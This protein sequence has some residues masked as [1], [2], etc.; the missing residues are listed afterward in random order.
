[1]FNTAKW[2][3]DNM[4]VEYNFTNRPA[5]YT[6]QGLGTIGSL[7]GLFKTFQHNYFG[8][9]AQYARTWAKNPKSFEAASPLL[10][11][12]VS[13]VMTAGLFGVMAVNQIDFL[14]RQMNSAVQT[15]LKAAGV[16][17]PGQYRIPEYTET[18]LKL[19]IPLEQKFGVPSALVNSD[20]SSTLAAPGLGPGDIFSLPTLDFL[21]GM[22]SKTNEGVIGNT[23][24]I[25]T[26]A[27]TGTYSDVDMYKFF[28]ATLPPVLL[29]EVERRFAGVSNEAMF[30][31]LPG[32]ERKTQVP[33]KITEE[34]GRFFEFKEGRYIVAN[35]Y[36]KMRGQIE[37]DIGGFWK[38]YL[39]GRSFEESII[40]KSIW[41]STK[42]SMNHRDKIDALVT[43][44]ASDGYDGLYDNIMFYTESAMDLGYDQEQFLEKVVNR[45]ETQSNT[46]LS[47]FKAFGERHN[48][49]RD[50]FIKSVLHNNNIILANPPGSK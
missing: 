13:M 23:F 49:S 25:F 47:R 10:M 7:F 37:R 38:R 36:K 5:M 33:K 18:I 26:K 12:A 2:M 50:D 44:A 39:G 1:M 35:P 30:S 17:D 29:A 3:T 32:F 43:A 34:R 22:T 16:K 42:I 41:Q 46:V 4:M 15:G 11:H 27:A 6:H 21:F 40:L 24:N 31:V 14:L 48:M 19:D 8:Q 45:M 9:V 28:K 20:V